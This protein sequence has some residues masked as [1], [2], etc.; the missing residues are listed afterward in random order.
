MSRLRSSFV[1]TWKTALTDACSPPASRRRHCPTVAGGPAETGRDRRPR[2]ACHKP[3]YTV[4][5]C[6]FGRFYRE[7]ESSTFPRDCTS[8]TL[9]ARSYRQLDLG[10]RRTLFR[11]AEA[12]T[13]V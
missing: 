9:M 8:E 10:E 4:T 3:H 12:H 5:F 2:P 1:V 7:C 6:I 13:P 11:L